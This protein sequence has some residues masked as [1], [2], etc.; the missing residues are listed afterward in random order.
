M[1]RIV[2][3]LQQLGLSDIEAQLYKGLLEAGSTTIMDL[4]NHVNMK[5][6]TVHFNIE[7]LIEKGLVIQTRQG[8]RRYIMAEPPEKL[9]T[10]IEEKLNQMSKLQQELPSVIHTINQT[11]PRNAVTKQSELLYYEGKNAVKNIYNDVLQ[12]KELRAY[13]T[14]K[15]DEIFPENVELFQKTHNKRKDMKIWEITDES[16]IHNEYINKMAKGRYH[17]K[18]IDRKLEITDYLIYDGKVAIIDID[19]INKANITGVVIANSN[20]YNSS[21]TL[22]DFIWQVLPGNND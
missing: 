14:S 5:R 3:Y 16:P 11:V 6:I 10:I 4:A 21:K 20:F 22:F 2:D 18:I 9:N 13:V 15:L 7:N 17:Y 8:A 19:D 12:A 1:K